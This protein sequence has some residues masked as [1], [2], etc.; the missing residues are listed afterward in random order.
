MTFM[1]SA[2]DNLWNQLHSL[3]GL[4]AILSL[5]VHYY[6]LKLFMWSMLNVSTLSYRLGRLLK[7]GMSLLPC[8]DLKLER[9]LLNVSLQMTAFPLEIDLVGLYVV[10]K[11]MIFALFGSAIA[12]AIVLMQYDF[13]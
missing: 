8:A 10:K 4:R 6:D 7:L 1:T 11:P 12:K 5:A 13:K 3:K 9:S 2:P